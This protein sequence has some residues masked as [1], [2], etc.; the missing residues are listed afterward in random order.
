MGLADVAGAFGR[1]HEVLSQA[2]WD[3]RAPA[4]GYRSICSQLLLPTGEVVIGIDDTIE[5]RWGAKY[6]GTRHL[7]RS[8]ALLARPLRQGQRPALAVADGVVPIPWA[9]RVWA[10]PF[11]TVLAP[12][13]VR[14]ER[15]A[16]ATRR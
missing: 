16:A 13:D 7:P 3:A 4:I 5:R 10:L 14:R 9:E 6:R 12:S 11:L 1:Y 2:R 8:G 15:K